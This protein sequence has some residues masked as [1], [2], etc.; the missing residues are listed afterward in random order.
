MMLGNVLIINTM[1]KL[2]IL[3]SLA[4]LLLVNVVEAEIYKR[5]DENGRIVYSNMKTP[6]ATRLDISPEV[7]N[8]K[9]ERPRTTTNT[10]QHKPASPESFP[11][12]DRQTQTQRDDKRK[13]ILMSELEAEKEALAQAQQAY[14][15][16]ESKPEVYHKRNADG[17]I[18]TFRNMAKFNSKMDALKAE[19]ESHQN[20]IH[21][22]QKEL[23][24]LD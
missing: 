4:L 24:A 6:G 2:M 11:R 22:L 23:S 20:N 12:V 1:K 3:I 7:N 17:S 15:E 16:G 14:A 21:M 9:D 5:I 10:A 8:I 19:V 18:S 13:E